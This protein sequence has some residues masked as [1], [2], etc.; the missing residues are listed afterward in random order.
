[1]AT[2]LWLILLGTTCAAALSCTPWTCSSESIPKEATREALQEPQPWAP[3]QELL[4]TAAQQALT[5]CDN[6][7]AEGGSLWA[8]LIDLRDPHLPKLASYHGN[9]KVYPASVIKAFY[10]VAVFHQVQ[11]GMLRLDR[12]LRR[13]L[14]LMIG[15]SDNQ[16]TNRI[17][18]RLTNTAAG[19]SLD[20]IAFEEFAYKRAWMNRY[21]RSIGFDSVNA[22]QKTWDGDP[23]GR[24]LQL[25]GPP[26]GPNYLNSNKLTTD[27]TALLLYLIDQRKVVSR[28]ACAAMFKLMKRK[29]DPDDQFLA[30]VLP[31]GARLWSKQGL[32]ESKR[33]DAGIIQLPNG[34]RF[35]LVVF[36]DKSAGDCDLLRRFARKVVS[37]Y[38][39]ES[40]T[41]P[42]G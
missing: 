21:F 17:V 26:E 33:H 22:C 15:I 18:D 20:G 39:G 6:P 35:I 13:D 40:P 25:L 11:Q 3:L 34:A 32:V 38:A 41:E 31:K 4:C 24:D 42:G 37:F 28:Q 7:K 14:E 5:E 29:P 1:M 9:E 2:R 19:D 23:F 10:M 16:A 30:G 36:T 8:T 12:A 27:E